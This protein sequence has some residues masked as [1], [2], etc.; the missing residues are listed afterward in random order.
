M[1]VL[2]HSNRI[3]VTTMRFK[4]ILKAHSGNLIYSGD[5]IAC[6]YNGAHSLATVILVTLV[7]E[8]NTSIKMNV[9]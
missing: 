4:L 8:E 2:L 5:E 7:T 3:T 1:T 9:P 6:V